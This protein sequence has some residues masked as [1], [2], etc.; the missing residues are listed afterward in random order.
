[1]DDSNPIDLTHI[2]FDEFVTFLFDRD[3]PPESEKRDPWYCHVELGEF[4]AHRICEYYVRLFRSPE[5][6]F[7]RFSKLQLDQGF[8]AMQGPNLGCSAYHV[9]HEAP[10]PISEREMCIRAMGDLFQLLFSNESLQWSVSMWWD[11][12]CYDWHCG[13]RDRAKGGEDEKLQDICFETLK[14]ILSLESDICQEA[15]LHGLGHFHHPATPRLIESYLSQRPSLPKE[16]RD[17]A[18][19]AARFDV[20]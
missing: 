1:M 2:S 11:S 3:V 9:V 5:F 18:L 19:A 16:R 17:Y 15:A 6:L 13:I 4:S 10:L 7:T 12:M 14:K 8:W 20:L